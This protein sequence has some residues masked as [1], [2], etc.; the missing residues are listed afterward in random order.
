MGTV[1]LTAFKR[2]EK[3]KIA[4]KHGFI[5]AVIYGNGIMGEAVK[6]KENEFIK[7]LKQHGERSK[8][9]FMFKDCEKFGII[10]DVDRNIMTNKVQHVDIQL[11][12]QG[13]IVNWQIPINYLGKEKLKSKR[14]L[15]QTELDKIEVTGN[16]ENIPNTIDLVVGDMDVD[17]VITIN[18]LKLHSSI[19]SIKPKDTV[20]GVVKPSV[21]N[22][23]S[24]DDD[25]E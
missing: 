3:G 6:F 5:P 7:V 24:D 4:R 23:D 12:K 10:K 16:V 25:D 13:E 14:L 1:L 20:L 9:K 8:I 21:N 11:V 19:K 22:D 15:F 17:R 18:D 2:E